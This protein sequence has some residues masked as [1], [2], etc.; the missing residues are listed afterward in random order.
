VQVVKA[1]LRFFSY[2]YHG[3]FAL[4]M[5][6][7]GALIAIA[8]GEHSVHLEMLPWT[9]HTLIHVLL[10]GGLFG[11]ITVILAIRR[12]LRPLFFLWALVVTY[13]LIKGYFLGGYRF[14]PDEFRSVV[15]LVLAALIALLGAFIQMFRKVR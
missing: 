11:L 4:V 8:H 10:F 13:Y 7:F 15:Y 12:K 14:T 2:L 9:D 6:V 1:L 3:L 5:M